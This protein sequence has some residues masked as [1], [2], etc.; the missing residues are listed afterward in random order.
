MAERDAGTGKRGASARTLGAAGG[1]MAGLAG[2]AGLVLAAGL[3]GCASPSSAPMSLADGEQGH[4]VDCSGF[5]LAAKDCVEQ[6]NELCDGDYE[7]IASTGQWHAGAVEGVLDS[8]DR[9]M[10]IRCRE[11][12]DG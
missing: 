6:A 8:V 2:A 5:R 10:I 11:P 3:G 1:R 4:L 12:D 7:I 9:G